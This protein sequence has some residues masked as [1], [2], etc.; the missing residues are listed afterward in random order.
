MEAGILSRYDMKDY[1]VVRHLAL[2]VLP[3]ANTSGV[4]AHRILACFKGKRNIAYKPI[5]RSYIVFNW[6]ADNEKES[7]HR[8][9][10]Y[11]SRQ[12]VISTYPL[13]DTLNHF[14]GVLVPSL[15]GSKVHSTVHEIKSLCRPLQN[16]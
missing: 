3:V 10:Q 9:W 11:H 15:N 7:D 8:S 13:T 4:E 16:L 6:S 2:L 14:Q 5:Y 1:L 12:I